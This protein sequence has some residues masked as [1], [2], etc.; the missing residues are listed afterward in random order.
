MSR[1]VAIGQA[2]TLAGYALAGVEVIE[3]T[4]PDLVR[5]AWQRIDSD[6]G[7]VLLTAD[8]RQA[9]PDPIGRKDV[10]WVVLPA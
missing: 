6:I 1:I 7:L 8:A 4:D 5:H 9:L 3:A 2:T 10:L